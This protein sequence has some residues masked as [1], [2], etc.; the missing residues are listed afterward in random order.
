MAMSHMTRRQYKQLRRLLRDNGRYALLLMDQAGRDVMEM[1]VY[2]REDALR[3]RSDVVA[4]C[5]R[6]N[7]PY[8][9]RHL[10]KL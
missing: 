6:L 5:K 7:I 2:Q 3:E 10:A 4:Y 8:N 9:F 1:L